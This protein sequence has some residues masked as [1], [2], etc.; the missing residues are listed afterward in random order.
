MTATHLAWVNGPGGTEQ[1]VIKIPH[2]QE[3]PHVLFAESI[4]HS[5]AAELKLLDGDNWGGVIDV[6][7]CPSISSH[8]PWTKNYRL[9]TGW[10]QPFFRRCPDMRRKQPIDVLKKMSRSK[11]GKRILAFDEWLSNGDR[12]GENLLCC[13]GGRLIPIDHE[14]SFGGIIC[15]LYGQPSDTKGL[16]L[17][18]HNLLKDREIKQL[19]SEILSNHEHH[20]AALYAIKKQWPAWANH[21]L[22]CHNRQQDILKFLQQR[23][24]ASWMRNRLGL[25]L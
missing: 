2:P 8:A 20:S 21:L 16:L 7:I 15:Q 19:F 17:Q 1:C 14:Q 12:H 23:A 11:R 25:I 13:E 10:A 4:A 6:P 9:V 5:L 18:H 22:P 3:A 24:K